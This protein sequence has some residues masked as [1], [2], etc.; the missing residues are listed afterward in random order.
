MISRV[1]LRKVFNKVFSARQVIWML[2]FI[3]GAFYFAESVKVMDFSYLKETTTVEKVNLP[4]NA[5]I[6]LIF[7]GLI[8]KIWEFCIYTSIGFWIGNKYGEWRNKK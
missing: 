8:D 7:L 5:M 3:A 2:I 4:V 6:Y 1:K